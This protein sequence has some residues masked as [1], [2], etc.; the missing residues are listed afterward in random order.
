MQQGLE[1]ALLFL[2][3]GLI[4]EMVMTYIKHYTDLLCTPF[5]ACCMHALAIKVWKLFAMWI[6]MFHKSVAQ[7]QHAQDIKDIVSLDP[8]TSQVI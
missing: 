5:E 1:L 8:S 6:Y 2:C 4:A 7:M 3:T